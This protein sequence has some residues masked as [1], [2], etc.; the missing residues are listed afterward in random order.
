MGAVLR[1]T[2]YVISRVFNVSPRTVDRII[3]YDAL[4]LAGWTDMETVN[5]IPD[6]LW[7]TLVADRAKDGSRAPSWWR[8]ACM[9]AL[10]MA[11]Q[12]GDL[13]TS[14]LIRTTSL[15]QT[16]HEYL[17]RVQAI[18]WNRKI[19]TLEVAT[20]DSVDEHSVT[21]IMGIGLRDM[22]L[23]DFACILIVPCPS[24]YR[25]TTTATERKSTSLSGNATSMG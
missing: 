2:G 25:G 5:T 18:V 21:R 12:N 1:V 9:F 14:S 4:L 19:F 16:A 7:W 22:V 24:F 17:R 20:A 23:G 13:N 8:R 3:S 15:P 10:P 11:D 6:H